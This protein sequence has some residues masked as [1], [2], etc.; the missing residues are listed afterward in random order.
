MLGL[1]LVGFVLWIFFCW[2]LVGIFL[3]FKYSFVRFFLRTKM[4]VF[5][6]FFKY[7]ECHIEKQSN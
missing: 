1:C 6:M 7:Y 5:F 3:L 4:T 2:W